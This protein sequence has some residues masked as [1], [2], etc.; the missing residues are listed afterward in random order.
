MVKKK[1]RYKNYKNFD[2]LRFYITEEKRDD[3]EKNF[4]IDDKVTIMS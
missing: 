1:L 3:N 4:L 2:K